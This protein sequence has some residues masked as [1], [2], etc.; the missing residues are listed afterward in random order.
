[1]RGRYT[2]SIGFSVENRLV[3]GECWPLRL[4]AISSANLML[5]DEIVASC[6]HSIG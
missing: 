5:C 4:P 3:D 1:M 2:A 6:Y